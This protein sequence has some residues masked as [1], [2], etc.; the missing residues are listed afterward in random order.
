MTFIY[1]DTTP[2]AAEVLANSQP[3]ML[4]NAKY[5]ES[6]IGKD[7]NFTSNT[8][9]TNDGYHKV[10]HFVNQ[11]MDPF[12][13]AST[14]QFYTKTLNGNQ[15]LVFM[16]SAGNVQQLTT[17]PSTVLTTAEFGTNT[18][19]PPAVTNQNGGWTYLPGGLI[20]QYGSMVAT[21]NNTT[22]VFPIAFSS[23]LYSLVT[24]LS[25]T[26]SGG[27]SYGVST[28]TT[29]GFI[30]TKNSTGTGTFFWQAIGN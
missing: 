6:N 7:H 27:I 14:G 4:A 5:L 20:L 19:Y 29:T 18:N 25:Q 12:S 10:I 17:F 2:G 1:T 21:G 3:L 24:T 13:I 22:I 16:N 30:F 15:Q 28:Q 11:L 26:S 9:N 8:S 23:G